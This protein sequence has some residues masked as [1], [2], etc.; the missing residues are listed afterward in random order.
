MTQIKDNRK[1]ELMLLVLTQFVVLCGLGLVFLGKRAT[2]PLPAQVI[3][4][5]TASA[6][7]LA[8]ALSVSRAT[9]QALLQERDGRRGQAWASV[10]DLKHAAGAKGAGDERG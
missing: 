3:N 10:Y 2:T 1:V 6:G 7:E 5:N 9:G 4:I 8:Q